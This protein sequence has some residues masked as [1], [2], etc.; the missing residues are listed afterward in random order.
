MKT[1]RLLSVGLL[2]LATVACNAKTPDE[3]R[4]AETMAD[5]RELSRQLRELDQQQMASELRR[6]GLQKP[7]AAIKAKYFGFDP[8]QKVDFYR[9]EEGRRIADIVLSYQTPSG[10]WSKRT[11][12]STEPR[13]LGQA[14][15]TEKNYIPT[16]D[17]NATSTQFWVMASAFNGTG[18]ERYAKAAERA[19]QLILLAQYPSGGWPQSFPLRGKYHDLITFNDKVVCDLLKIVS[20]AARGEEGLDFLP[21]PLRERAADSLRRGL[22][23][24]VDAQ[25]VSDGRAT[26][27]GAQLDPQ[28]LAPAAA[29]AFEPVA[30]STAESAELVL[31]L[32]E[33]EEPTD[34]IR[35]VIESAHQWFAENQILGYRWEKG[36]HDYRELVPDADANPLWARFYEPGGDNRPVFGDRDGKVYY[37][38]RELSLERNLGY[39]WY[40]KHPH[41]VLKKFAK[42]RQRHSG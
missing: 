1:Y 19:L 27:W 26:I 40:T 2:V 4:P 23:M 15:G 37:D 39:G 38:V 11:D 36:Q 29:R 3:R 42:W 13:R 6:A 31:F 35:K 28:T 20:A 24:I 21:A 5:Y 34:D 32:M 14:Y 30:L 17:N 22:Q 33:L 9:T 8:E 7:A 18:D 12:M 41:K 16:F 25:V 10:G